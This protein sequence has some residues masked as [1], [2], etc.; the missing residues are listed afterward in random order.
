MARILSKS[1]LSDAV[2]RM[3]IEAP[4]IA[5]GRRAGQFVILRTDSEWGERIPLTIADADAARGSIDIVFQTVGVTTKRL[6]L[7]EPG[8]RLADITG[9][10][11]R[12]TEIRDYGTA[13]RRGWVVVVGGGVGVAPAH[14]IAQ[15]FHA[16]GNRV[17]AIIGARTRELVIMEEEMRRASDELIVVTDDGSAGRQ[18][19]VTAPLAECCAGPERPDEVV[20]VG[21]PMM[22][23]FAAETTRPFGV[24]TTASLNAIMIDGTGMCG[25]CRVTVGGRTRFVCV[26]GPEFDA[27]QVDFDSFIRRSGAFRREEKAHRCRSGLFGRAGGAS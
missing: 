24:K 27:H 14:P 16:A 1:R 20:I 18:G 13:D 7:L 4:L 5:R 22:M 17:T 26:D 15:A 6:S 23:K 12:P 2:Y 9:P 19:L 11:G 3:G 21:P 10:L 25:G 8:D